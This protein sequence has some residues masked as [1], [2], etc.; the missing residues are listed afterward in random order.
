M[1]AGLRDNFGQETALRFI[2]NFK[3]WISTNT[4]GVLVIQI[5]D[6]R[7]GGWDQPFESS[8]ITG[9]ITKPATVLQYNWYKLQ[10]YFQT[11]QLAYTEAAIPAFRQVSFIYFPEENDKGATLNFHLTGREK[12]EVEASLKRGSNVRAFEQ[13]KMLTR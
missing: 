5:R 7:K 12:K 6:T 13:V 11:D 3:D 9:V 2:H 10:D 1:D 4:S 8:A